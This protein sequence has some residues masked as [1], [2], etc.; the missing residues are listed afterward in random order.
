MHIKEW[1]SMFFPVVPLS[2]QLSTSELQSEKREAVL[3]LISIGDIGKT[4]LDEIISREVTEDDKTAMMVC[5]VMLGSYAEVLMREFKISKS[6]LLFPDAV[7]QKAKELL[8]KE[9]KLS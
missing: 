7:V 8:E 1:I 2:K 3:Q 9:Y 5:S 6:D 4:K